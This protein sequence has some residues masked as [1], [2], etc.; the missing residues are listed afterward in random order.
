MTLTTDNNFFIAWSIIFTLQNVY[1]I[2]PTFQIPRLHF[3]IYIYI[4][5]YWMV[6]FRIQFDKRDDFDFDIVKIPFLD[7]DVPRSTSYGVNIS[8]LIRF[9]R[10]PIILMTFILVIKCCL[11]NFSNKVIDIINFMRHFQNFIGGIST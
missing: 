4:Y 1:K 6:L 9:A 7:G 11:S 10:L 2:R 8:Q 3:W 5:K